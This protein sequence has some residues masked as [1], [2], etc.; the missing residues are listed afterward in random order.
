MRLPSGAFSAKRSCPW[1]ACLAPS[2]VSLVIGSWNCRAL[3][4]Q[5]EMDWGDREHKLRVVQSLLGFHDIVCL[6]EVHGCPEEFWAVFGS[7]LCSHHVYFNALEC[8]A[9]GIAFFAQKSAFDPHVSVSFEPIVPGW[10]SIMS[11]SQRIELGAHSFDLANVRNHGL[12][13]HRMHIQSSLQSSF[14]RAIDFPAEHAIGLIGDVNSAVKSEAAID[15]A[16]APSVEETCMTVHCPEFWQQLLGHF[17]EL[18]TEQVN[19]FNA[20]S[21]QLNISSRFFLSNPRWQLMT[22]SF[23]RLTPLTP[24]I[25]SRT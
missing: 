11:V 5:S 25:A 17:V 22:P 6:Q 20:S 13:N 14:N 15:V 18:K 8:G 19:H 10:L 21:N 3:L 2:K 24:P 7:L 9:G 1:L 12:S 16:S 23:P 4:T